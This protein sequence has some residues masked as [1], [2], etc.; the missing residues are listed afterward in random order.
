VVVM[1]L[2]PQLSVSISL[3]HDVRQFRRFA[4]DALQGFGD[5]RDDLGFCSR[6]TPSRVIRTLTKGML[7]LLLVDQERPVSNSLYRCAGI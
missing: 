3:D 6:V 1:P 7:Y 4:E 5:F 2:Y